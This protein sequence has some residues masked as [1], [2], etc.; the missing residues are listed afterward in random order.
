MPMQE[1]MT[2]LSFARESGGHSE[3]VKL[4]LQLQAEARDIPDEVEN[5]THEL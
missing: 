4:L 1:G 2:A 3:V 5:W